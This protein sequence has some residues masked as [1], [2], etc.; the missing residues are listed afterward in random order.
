VF[1]SFVKGVNPLK[2][3]KVGAD[4]KVKVIGYRALNANK[5]V[6]RFS[7]IYY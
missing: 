5:S 7:P 6:S 3:F 1:S 2:S 4:I